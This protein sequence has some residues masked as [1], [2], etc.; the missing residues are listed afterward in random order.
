MTAQ[1]ATTRDIEA[2]IGLDHSTIARAQ[3]RPEI[4]AK[5]EHEIEQLIN[6][7]L[8][9]ARATM[10][11]LAAIGNTKTTDKDMLKLSLDASKAIIAQAQGAPGSIINTL[12]Q[13]NHA[14]E[15]AQELD[16]IAAFLN[17]Q[18][19]QAATIDAE[20]E[21]PIQIPNDHSENRTS[22]Q[23]MTGIATARTD[24]IKFATLP[25]GTEEQERQHDLGDVMPV[26]S[27]E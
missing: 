8:K 5:I 27:I 22:V 17:H 1:G 20:I 18:W 23:E 19:R 9:P 15:Q 2:K 13:I 3:Q 4:K 26:P 25:V 12:I 7:G 6:R 16:G 24:C 11:R 14:P 21:Q 10:C